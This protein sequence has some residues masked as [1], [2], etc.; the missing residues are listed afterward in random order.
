MFIKKIG[1]QCGPKYSVAAGQ[2]NYNEDRFCPRGKE[3]VNSRLSVG[4]IQ[5]R[6]LIQNV[7]YISL[8][9]CLFGRLEYSADG[10]I[11]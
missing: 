4:S 2:I 9:G 7:Q 8:R 11:P 6:G 10:N 3:H 1:I 5:E